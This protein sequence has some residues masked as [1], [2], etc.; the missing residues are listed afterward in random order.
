VESQ[1]EKKNAW[2]EILKGLHAKV[3]NGLPII[4]GAADAG[5]SAKCAR[6]LLENMREP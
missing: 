6:C 1:N 3:S 4:S 5:I 2:S